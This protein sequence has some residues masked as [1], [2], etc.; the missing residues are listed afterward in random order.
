MIPVEFELQSCTTAI[1]SETWGN[2][3]S[4]YRN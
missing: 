1:E 4:L 2:V 3:K